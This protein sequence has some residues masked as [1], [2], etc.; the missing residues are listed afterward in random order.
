MMERASELLDHTG[1]S[2]FDL[3]TREVGQLNLRNAGGDELTEVSSYRSLGAR[4]DS[5]EAM[6]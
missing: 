3:R 2:V 1:S 5:D 6:A 4:R